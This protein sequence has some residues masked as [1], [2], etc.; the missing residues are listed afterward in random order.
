MNSEGSVNLFTQDF[1]GL[2]DLH[3]EP[4]A[5]S[6]VWTDW[7]IAFT[8]FLPNPPNVSLLWLNSFVLCVTKVS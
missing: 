5:L 8:L 6:G 2:L 4:I 3:P 1:L 7:A